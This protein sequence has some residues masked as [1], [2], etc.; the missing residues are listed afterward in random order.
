MH[1]AFLSLGSNLG[2]RVFNIQ[3]ALKKISEYVGD[4]KSVGALYETEPW[5]FSSDNWFVNTAIELETIFSPNELLQKCLWIESILG[6]KRSSATS[7]YSSRLIDIDILF[8][9]NEI[10]NRPN[11]TI[12][13]K[14][15]HKRKFVLTSLNDIAPELIH[16]VLKQSVK[17]LLENCTDEMRL[18]KLHEKLM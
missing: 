12:P 1:R 17:T 7:V 9:D 4:I 8:F 18:K 11:L 16:P 3:N 2:N 6:R 15:L 10:L 14:N 5:G 13:H